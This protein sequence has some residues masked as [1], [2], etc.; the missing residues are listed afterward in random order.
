MS[1]LKNVPTQEPGPRGVYV[2]KAGAAWGLRRGLALA[3]R[4]K[5][6]IAGAPP[7]YFPLHTHSPAATFGLHRA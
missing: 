5:D 3:G 7:C 2:G 6:L 1:S 4:G